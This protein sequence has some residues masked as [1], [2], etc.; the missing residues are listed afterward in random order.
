MAI[1]PRPPMDGDGDVR[2]ALR[3]LAARVR[4]LE[5]EGADLR[6]ELR[7]EVRARRIVV[8]DERG[9]ERIVLGA[10]DRFGHVTV[11][12]ASVPPESTCVEL[13]AVDAVEGDGAELGVALI[14]RGDTVA[15]FN[16]FEGRRARLWIDD[17]PDRA[18]FTEER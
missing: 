10:H 5:D 18:D 11:F 7:R 2:D 8:V 15:T 17:D 14:D 16:L 1:G 3:E 9:Q 13:F 4:W 6:A 12:A